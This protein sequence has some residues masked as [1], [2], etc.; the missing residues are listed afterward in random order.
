MSKGFS[1]SYWLAVIAFVFI[2]VIA[3]LLVAK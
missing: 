3:V 2:L 1:K